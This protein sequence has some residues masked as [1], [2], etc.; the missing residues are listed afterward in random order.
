[1]KGAAT[2]KK[3]GGLTGKLLLAAASCLVT[4]GLAELLLPAL[5]DLEKVTLAYD[6]LLGF[7]GRARLTTVWRREMAGG[8]RIVRTNSEGFHDRQR[9]RERTPGSR[10][11]VF[12]GD[13]FL[14]AYQVEIAE[15]FSQLV[16]ANL[17]RRHQ[18]YSSGDL[19]MECLNQG[20]H[21]YGLGVHY[22][23]VRERLMAWQPDTVVLVLFLGNDLH[24]NYAPLA[25]SAVPR[26]LIGAGGNLQYI[27]APPY[28]LKTWLRDHVLA[29]STL[30]RLLWMKLI[31]SS[32]A[33]LGLARSAGMVSTPMMAADSPD[34]LAEMSALADRLLHE[35]ADFLAAK[36]V[37]LM[38]YV[39]PDPLRVHDLLDV[40]RYRLDPT[41]PVPLYRRDKAF[42]ET[43]LLRSLE[44]A[45]I[46]YV[47]PLDEFME[48][49]AAGQEIY[50]EGY[51]HFSKLGH[52]LSAQLL[53]PSLWA[54]E[55]KSPTLK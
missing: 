34:R 16:A 38:V 36:G 49:I 4:L 55:G 30:I 52:E 18:R 2:S 8:Q 5:L 37:G 1:M 21:G 51:G 17:T 12:L 48:R 9:Q 7:R 50:R 40:A 19:R 33:A 13:S 27:P 47:Y 28:Q 10:R 46:P 31:K 25:S 53:A 45:G 22:L 3:R 32:P 42:L 44:T 24:D 15:N 54:T 35:I 23:Y 11:L 20:V 14:E 43:Q 29:R 26:F 6:P 41:A 39:I